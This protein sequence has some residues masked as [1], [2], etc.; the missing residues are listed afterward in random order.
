M[1]EPEFS[2]RIEHLNGVLKKAAEHYHAQ[3]FSLWEL[4]SNEEGEYTDY[5]YYDERNIKIRAPDGIHL[6]RKGAEYIV[7]YFL[8]FLKETG[9][10]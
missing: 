2:K 4:S 7:S 10:I 9:I 6:S 5:Q 8:N 3:Y 1:K